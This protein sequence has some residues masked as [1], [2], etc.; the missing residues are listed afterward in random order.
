MLT[1]LQSNGYGRVCADGSPQWAHRVSYVAFVGP[2]P[3]GLEIDHRC[4]QRSCVN[5][6][7]LR[8]VTH[9]VNMAASSPYRL[10]KHRHPTCVR[11]HPMEG[12]NLMTGGGR[13][14]CR[15]CHNERSREWFRGRAARLCGLRGGLRSGRRVKK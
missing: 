10:G 14:R 7:H 2:I 4:H 3:K 12:E 8:A 15:A 13:R 5:P 11:G 6:Q 1:A 9:A